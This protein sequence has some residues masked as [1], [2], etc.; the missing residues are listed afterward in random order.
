[1]P[2]KDFLDPYPRPHP[3]RWVLRGSWLIGALIL[4][5]LIIIVLRLG[6]LEDFIRLFEQALPL[7]VGSGDLGG[8]DNQVGDAVLFDQALEFAIGDDLHVTLADQQISNEENGED[9]GDE[10]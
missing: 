1:M 8:S 5:A 4:A 2:E 9:N 3:S 6:E 7:F 10:V